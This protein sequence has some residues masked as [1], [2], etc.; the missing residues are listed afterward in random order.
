MGCSHKK[1]EVVAEGSW[2]RKNPTIVKTE[3]LRVSRCKTCGAI[4]VDSFNE[5][6]FS[7]G[8][9]SRPSCH[10]VGRASRRG[11]MRHPC[12]QCDDSNCTGFHLAKGKTG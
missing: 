6:C 8:T 3:N 2:N 4:R 7:T 1:R 9:W 10:S 5:F 12:R 11:T